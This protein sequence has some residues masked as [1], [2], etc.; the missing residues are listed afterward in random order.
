MQKY[1][2]KVQ[3]FAKVVMINSRSFQERFSEQ[4][5]DIDSVII[6]INDQ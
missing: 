2:I 3:K 6:K 4:Q 1:R 5:P